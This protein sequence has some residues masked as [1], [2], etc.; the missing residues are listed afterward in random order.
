MSE[1]LRA[2]Y[3]VCPGVINAVRW[4]LRR[5]VRFSFYYKY[6]RPIIGWPEARRVENVNQ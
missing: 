2:G 3:E 5:K 4:W 1:Q 6:I